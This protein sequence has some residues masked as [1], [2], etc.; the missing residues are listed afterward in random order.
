MTVP[1]HTILYSAMHM[2]FFFGQELVAL[3]S[4]R[5]YMEDVNPSSVKS[6]IK[7]LVQTKEGAHWVRHYFAALV[8][9]KKHAK[10]GGKRYKTPTLNA[11]ALKPIINIHYPQ[12]IYVKLLIMILFIV[13]Y[14]DL[15]ER[16]L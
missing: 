16:V 1:L 13:Y 9:A 6:F 14:L 15:V 12:V 7:F 3:Y 8:V 10:E 2:P 5:E 11:L 4:M